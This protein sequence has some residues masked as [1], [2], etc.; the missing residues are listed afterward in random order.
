MVTGEVSPDEIPFVIWLLSEGE[1]NA[2]DFHNAIA[3]F[4]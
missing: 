3:A 2:D 1:R 4:R